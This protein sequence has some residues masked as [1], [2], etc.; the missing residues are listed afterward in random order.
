MFASLG[1]K[2]GTRSTEVPLAAISPKRQCLTVWPSLCCRFRLAYAT[3]AVNFEVAVER[4]E[5]GIF[6]NPRS[7]SELSPSSIALRSTPNT[8]ACCP[9][10]A[11]ARAKTYSDRAGSGWYLPKSR[12]WT[13]IVSRR[14]SELLGNDSSEVSRQTRFDLQTH[15]HL[16]AR[17]RTFHVIQRN[18]NCSNLLV[19]GVRV[20]AFGRCV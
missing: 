10:S 8:F 19:L 13:S 4:Q 14:I 11:S 15:A 2:Q 3:S 18:R 7:F 5:V 17:R 12:C 1:R 20:S 9:R 16:N 6:G